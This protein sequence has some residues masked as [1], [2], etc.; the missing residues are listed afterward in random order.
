MSDEMTE[1][2][3]MP[4]FMGTFIPW[5]LL[6][7]QGIIAL[8][9]GIALLSYPVETLM[10]IIVFLGA[11]W[12]ASAIFTLFSLAVDKSHWGMKLVLGI[13]GLIL[14]IL[15]L[16]YPLY[17]TFVVPYIFVIIV[18]V[19]A[20][21]YGFIALYGAFTGKGWGIGLLGLLSIIFGL[22]ILA[23]PIAS[24]IAVPFVFGMLGIVFGLAA[25]IGSFMLRS[26]QK[27]VA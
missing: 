4:R 3:G 21:F 16:A 6:L 13:L 18:G 17:S 2:T 19:L 15:I 14:G 5:W 7:V 10:V 9:L 8:I 1:T 11:Y 24:T 22:I 27:A 23:N 25:I 20:M 26:A 12:C